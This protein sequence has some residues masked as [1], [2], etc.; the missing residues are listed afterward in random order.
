[1]SAQQDTAPLQVVVFNGSPHGDSGVTA[2]YIRYLQIRFADVQFDTIPVG[3]RIN[4][5]RTD[6]VYLDEAFTRARSA[7]VIIWAFP[8][9]LM[10]IP[11]QLKEFIELLFAHNGQQLLSG[12]VATSISTSAHFFDHAAH[13]YMQ[14]IS[15]DLGMSYVRGF[16][17]EMKDLL[18]QAGR[19]NFLGYGEDFF[20]RVKGNAIWEDRIVEPLDRH[21]TDLGAIV[22]P[23][24]VKKSGHKKVVIV[25]D[26]DP[27]DTNLQRMI[28]IFMQQTRH[29]VDLLELKDIRVV[30]GC[31]GCMTCADGS[32]CVHNDEY[33][34]AFEKVRCADVVI[35]AGAIR[36]RYFSARLKRFY[37]RYFSN[38]HRPVLKADLLG[39]LVSGPLRQLPF[40]QQTLEANIEVGR[41]QRLGIVA[42]DCSS[43]QEVADRVRQ[44]AL[45][46]DRYYQGRTWTSPPTF[47]G[48]GGHKLFRDLVYEYRGVM[49]ADY[50]FYK[51]HGLFD[52]S[53]TKKKNNM[54]NHLLILLQKIPGGGKKFKQTMKKNRI[55]PYEIVLER[56]KNIVINR[57]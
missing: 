54:F 29:P 38:G 57:S 47:L 31:L 41:H 16:S 48:A 55:R 50:A 35:Y 43:A 11:A 46:V 39:Y 49:R 36:D 33:A 12:K 45:S 20:A 3:G 32:A 1:M 5:L 2:Q 40:M 18:S 8:V 21:S 23:D 6:P 17:A 14:E 34:Q 10:L 7:D 19:D 30:S 9:Y 25:S 24:R 13:D 22:A 42:D 52:F 27:G 51:S 28:E 4:R 37:D 53:T 26:A 15:A 56:E 44:M